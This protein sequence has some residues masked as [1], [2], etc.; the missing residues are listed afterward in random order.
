MLKKV[1][2]V[3]LLALGLTACDNTEVGDVSLG[4]AALFDELLVGFIQSAQVMLRCR[5]NLYFGES[6]DL[7]Q[8]FGRRLQWAPQRHSLSQ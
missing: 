8:Q 7:N 5:R 4:F 6:L 1:A 2:I 3:S